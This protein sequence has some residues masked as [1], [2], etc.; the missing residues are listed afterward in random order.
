MEESRG[1]TITLGSLWFEQRNVFLLVMFLVE[2]ENIW[3]KIE[4]GEGK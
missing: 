3:M 2:S 4:E 1:I